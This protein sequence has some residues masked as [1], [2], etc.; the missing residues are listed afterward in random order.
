MTYYQIELAILKYFPNKITEELEHDISINVS[1][2]DEFLKFKCTEETQELYSFTSMLLFQ[3][4]QENYLKVNDYI[5][6][7]DI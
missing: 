4:A 6:S 5:R 2:Y 1:N 7:K 3:K